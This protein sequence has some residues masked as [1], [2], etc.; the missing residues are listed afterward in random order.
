M[1]TG[2]YVFVPA[3]LILAA[4]LFFL[5]KLVNVGFLPW[6]MLLAVAAL[7]FFAVWSVRPARMASSAEPSAEPFEGLSRSDERRPWPEPL[8][9]R[10]GTEFDAVRATADD[11]NPIV[12]VANTSVNTS[13]DNTSNDNTS[14]DNTSDDNTS[15]LPAWVNAAPRL[16][17]DGNLVLTIHSG[18]HARILD[19]EVALTRELR[20]AANDYIDHYV[21]HGQGRDVRNFIQAAELRD[22]VVADE[23]VETRKHSFG[24]V[25]YD[26]GDT[27]DKMIQV[28]Q[29]LR[30]G[31][32]AHAVLW[33][34][35][36]KAV[37]EDR[38]W[39]SGLSSG[40]VLALLATLFGCLS[41]DRATDGKYR[42]RLGLGATAVA[43]L[44]GVGTYL[45]MA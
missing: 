41:V 11:K 43:G 26:I 42:G 27:Q 5:I 13:D 39:R 10:E 37:V 18:P 14:N 33:R 36:R 31:P 17:D 35:A 4:G 20:D 44:V 28:H 16:D 38:L 21:E 23:H 22:L 12:E 7:G 29:R 6:L 15:T 2:V 24:E 3:L 8:F 32:E 34:W 1:E 25:N 19:C 40:A 30:F 9:L 45:F